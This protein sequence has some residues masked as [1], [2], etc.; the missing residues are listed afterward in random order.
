MPEETLAQLGITQ[1]PRRSIK[2]IGEA[3]LAEI[4]E[5]LEYE[6]QQAGWRLPS[7]G[8]PTWRRIDE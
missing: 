8:E 2:E 3:Q 7:P 5:D 4:V 6:Y 1:R